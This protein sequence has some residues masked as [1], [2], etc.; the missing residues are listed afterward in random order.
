MNTP[1]AD[2]LK[3]LQTAHLKASRTGVAVS[4]ARAALDEALARDRQADA[5]LSSAIAVVLYGE[6]EPNPAR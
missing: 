2:Q 3:R 5:E 6:H 4:Q 1:T